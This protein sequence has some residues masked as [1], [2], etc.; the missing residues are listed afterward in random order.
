ML[1]YEAVPEKQD[2]VLNEKVRLR[3][4][5]HNPGPGSIEIPDPRNDASDQPTIG[6]IGPAFPQGKLISNLAALRE[7]NGPGFSPLPPPSI[8]IAPNATWEGFVPLTPMAPI[9]EPGEYRVR[10]KLA[11]QAGRVDS[12]ETRFRVQAILPS[13]VQLGFGLESRPAASGEV[14]FIQRGENS[15]A[16]YAFR[17]AEGPPDTVE[18][19]QGTPIRRATVGAGATDVAA[20]RRDAPFFNEL[21]QWIVWREGKSIKALS[22]VMSQPL[23]AD[24]PA[25]PAGLV[26]PPLKTTGGPVEVL[27]LSGDRQEISLVRFSSAPNG[28][29]P[30][31]RVVWQ[32]RLPAAPA[33]AIAALAPANLQ[34]ARHVALIVQRDS[35]FEI[36]HSRY[37]EAGRMEAFQ[38]V[39]VSKGKLLP[40]ALAL[41]ID[42]AGHA[43]VAVLSADGDAHSCILAE[44]E[45]DPSGK[46]VGPARIRNFALPGRPSA[47]A[48]LY[49]YG[50]GA[51]LRF[52]AAVE[53]ESHGVLRLE[54]D[55]FVPVSAQ[56]KPTTPMLL[57]PGSESS[58]LLYADP[59]RGLYFEPLR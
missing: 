41:F 49:T 12:K 16:L 25:E 15:S 19:A 52:D 54:F 53:V 48:V 59:K 9:A 14:V 56:G 55:R 42:G 29:S 23:S 37:T 46:A 45:F 44:A 24:L 33:G 5:I 50:Q 3:L 11:Y 43:K 39:A 31:A 20:P 58:Y 13:S 7:R 51:Q 35:G 34:S 40:D 26:R 1:T 18:I 30:S 21:L 6:L 2:Y 17:F 28:E 10:S 22:S 38:S 57:T 36:L 32:T 27:A 8:H 47:G 4:R